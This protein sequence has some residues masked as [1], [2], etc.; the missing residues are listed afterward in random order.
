MI[1]CAQPASTHIRSPMTTPRQAG[2]WGLT[3]W[4]DGKAFLRAL[5]LCVLVAAGWTWWIERVQPPPGTVF[6]RLAPVTGPWKYYSRGAYRGAWV[7]AMKVHCD[8]LVHRDCRSVQIP[9]GEVVMVVKVKLPSAAGSDEFVSSIQSS[10]R[11]Y[12]AEDDRRIRTRWI[13]GERHAV[14]DAAMLV[15]LASYGIQLS[16]RRSTTVPPASHAMP[17][18]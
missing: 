16:L 18:A 4:W 6:E 2:R 17:S 9:D 15:F 12:Y 3:F 13:D 7:G 10:W 8:A 14:W 11:V 5:V 1:G